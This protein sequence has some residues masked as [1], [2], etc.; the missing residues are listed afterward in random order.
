MKIKVQMR[1]L[2]LKP[3][4]NFLGHALCA[5][6]AHATKVLLHPKEMFGTAPPEK[7]ICITGKSASHKY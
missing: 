4:M 1:K 5:G 2:Q 3:G 6:G 7:K